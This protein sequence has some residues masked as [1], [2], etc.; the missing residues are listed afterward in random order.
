MQ[1]EVLQIQKAE[2]VYTLYVFSF[3]GKCSLMMIG[4]NKSLTGNPTST[5]KNSEIPLLL[6][7]LK[8]SKQTKLV[9]DSEI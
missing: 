8:L 4:I 9:F 2:W 3:P 6:P 7:T 1:N 5:K